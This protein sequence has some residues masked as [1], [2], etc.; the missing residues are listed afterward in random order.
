M[1]DRSTPIVPPGRIVFNSFAGA[2]DQ[3]LRQL[4]SSTKSIL[5]A[6]IDVRRGILPPRDGRSARGKRRSVDAPVV[7]RLLSWDDHSIAVSAQWFDTYTAALEDASDVVE[8]IPALQT[9]LVLQR[10]DD[11]VSHSWYL[12]LDR[13]VLVAERWWPSNRDRNNHLEIVRQSLQGVALVEGL[14]P[15][16]VPL[17]GP[18]RVRRRGGHASDRSGSSLPPIDEPDRQAP[19]KGSV[20]RERSQRLRDRSER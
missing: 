12:R 2:D 20:V 14:E 3:L 4:S 10:S 8:R 15:L 17:P 19:V 11:D 7:W 13:D 9:V 5:T 18:S 6:E 1:T 16:P